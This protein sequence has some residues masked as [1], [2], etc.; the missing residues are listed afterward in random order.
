[1]KMVSIK[2]ENHEN[3][4]KQSS[5]RLYCGRA[6]LNEARLLYSDKRRSCDTVG[7]MRDD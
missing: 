3:L 5:G 2:P 7:V 4:R 6:I 1:M